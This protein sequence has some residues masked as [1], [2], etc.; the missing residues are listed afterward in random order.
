MNTQEFMKRDLLQ[1]NTWPS[2]AHKSLLRASHWAWQNY[3]APGAIQPHTTRK[4]AATNQS[5]AHQTAMMRGV[6]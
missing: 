3:E 1:Q 6:Q 2:F 5:V 4:V